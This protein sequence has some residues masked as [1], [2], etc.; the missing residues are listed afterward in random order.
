MNIMYAVIDNPISIAV[1]G[2]SCEDLNVRMSNG[3]VKTVNKTLGKYFLEHFR[4][5]INDLTPILKQTNNKFFKFNKKPIPLQ[6]TKEIYNK[7]K[8]FEEQELK[9]FSI[10]YLIINNL[11]IF[12][13]NI[14]L[15]S[16]VTFSSDLLMELKQKIMDIL[17]SEK[18]FDKKKIGKENI[19]AKFSNIIDLVT[20]YAPVKIIVK[21]KNEDEIIETLNEILEETKKIQLKKKIEVLE[22]EVSLNLDQNLY[23]ELLSLRNQLKSG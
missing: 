15:I 8:K 22:N 6:K 7:T 2:F 10:L 12:R 23:S 1:P 19:D 18:F 16:E 17:L 4:Q 14:E 3:S 20:D 11:D 21:N 9:E 5:K 13:K